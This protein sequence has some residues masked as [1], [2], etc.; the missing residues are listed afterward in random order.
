MIIKSKKG[1]IE[2]LKRITI[3]DERIDERYT[4]EM[5]IEAIRK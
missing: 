5:L 2:L 1:C 4:S 3:V